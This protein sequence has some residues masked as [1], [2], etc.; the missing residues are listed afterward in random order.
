MAGGKQVRQ[1]SGQVD[2]CDGRH[3]VLPAHQ[4]AKHAGQVVDEGGQY[5]DH[6][7]RHEG[8]PA[9]PD[10]RWRDHGEE[11]LQEGLRLGQA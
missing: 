11:H 1:T 3:R 8:H 10:G 2:E 7:Q 5:A 6:Q 4:A 9:A